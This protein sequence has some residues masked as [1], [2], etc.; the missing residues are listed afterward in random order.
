MMHAEESLPFHQNQNIFEDHATSLR[1]LSTL[2]ASHGAK[3]EFG[4]DWTFIEGVKQF[5]PALLTDLLATGHGIHTH[6]HESQFD[7]GE[8]NARLL[9][10]GLSENVVGNGG[11]LKSGPGGTNWVGYMTSFTDD[12][13]DQLFDVGIGYKNPNTQ[14]IVGI[15]HAFRPSI[16]GDWT[17]HDPGGPLIYL[18]CN[19]PESEGAAIDFETIQ[20]WMDDV[21]TR[22]DPDKVNTMYWHDS[23]HQYGDPVA[24]QAR[25]D[26][27]EHLLGSYFDHLVAEGRIEWKTFTEMGQIYAQWEQTHCGE[28]GVTIRMPSRM[29]RAG[30]SC[31]CTVDVCN[32]D[33]S[34]ITDHPLFVILDVY[35]NLFFAPSFNP[36][37]DHYLADYPTFDPGR[38]TVEVLPVFSWPESAGSASGIQWIA[39][40]TNPEITGIVGDYDIFV[41][42]WE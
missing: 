13:E 2:F 25:L 11:F 10:A 39:A 41:F 18:G 33:V 24:A 4:P 28:T 17:V 9:Q 37:F 6:A 16:T 27:W 14:E 21:L 42:G 23:L 38:T 30:D 32:S 7:L 12:S 1:L 34:P 19:M 5:D 40:L 22:I 29:F 36:E 26:E 31:G 35:G 8:V 20:A 3:L 15:G